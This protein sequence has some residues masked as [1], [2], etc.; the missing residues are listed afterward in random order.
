MK[1]VIYGIIIACPLTALVIYFALSGRQEVLI[2]Q[3]KHEVQQQLRSEEFQRNFSRAWSEF[4][5]PSQHEMALLSSE[6]A[7]REAR[8]E[9]LKQLRSNIEAFDNESFGN[10]QDDLREMK[11]ALQEQQPSQVQELPN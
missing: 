11:K 8:I 4:D 6:A 1:S 2:Q 9:K 10:L 7:E 3:K 5:Q